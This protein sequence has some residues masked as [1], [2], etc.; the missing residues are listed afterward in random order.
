MP[1]TTYRDCKSFVIPLYLQTYY[2]YS[3]SLQMNIDAMLQHRHHRICLGLCTHDG[4]GLLLQLNDTG[5]RSICVIA[6]K[7]Y[8][9]LVLQSDYYV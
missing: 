1:I 7:F 2:N 6:Q 8:T 3:I 9:P 5:M 4:I